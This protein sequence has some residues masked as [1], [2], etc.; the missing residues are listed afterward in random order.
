MKYLFIFTL[1][2]CSSIEF[3]EGIIMELRCMFRELD[4]RPPRNLLTCETISLSEMENRVLTNV[5]AT[6]NVPGFTIRNTEGLIIENGARGLSFIP[7]NMNSFLPNLQVFY[8]VA[9]GV[10]QILS[11]DLRQFPRLQAFYAQHN[12]ITSLPSNLF[13]G[14]PQLIDLEIVG[15][16]H[17]NRDNSLHSIGFNML[18]NAIRLEFVILRNNFCVNERATNRAEVLNLNARLHTY[19]AGGLVTST[20]R[21]I[22][23]PTSSVPPSSTP[24]GTSRT[25]LDGKSRFFMISLIIFLCFS[26]LNV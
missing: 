4:G 25:T 8:L 13:E 9:T 10:S 15:P 5:I 1:I 21:P 12:S 19:C 24:S 22:L 20:A 23:P 3:N 11:T 2:L 26:F 17:F 6:S 16:V 7:S 14:N 18:S